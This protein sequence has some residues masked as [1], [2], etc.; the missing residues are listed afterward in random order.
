MGIFLVFG[1][2]SAIKSSKVADLVRALEGQKIQVEIGTSPALLKYKAPEYSHVVLVV[3]A[4]MPP[5]ADMWGTFFKNHKIFLAGALVKSTVPAQF[6]KFF[7]FNKD[8]KFDAPESVPSIV[9]WVKEAKLPEERPNLPPVPSIEPGVSITGLLNV[10]ETS[11]KEPSVASVVKGAEAPTSFAV[12]DD[13]LPASMSIE[14]DESPVAADGFSMS[15]I[16]A[17][18]DASAL[19]FG[20]PV[21]EV[22]N[23][24]DAGHIGESD[25]DP[26]DDLGDILSDD[27]P[28]ASRLE[29]SEPMVD[30]SLG[31]LSLQEASVNFG[32]RSHVAEAPLSLPS[33]SLVRDLGNEP[34]IDSLQEL[35]N[36]GDDTQAV[37]VV[38]RYALLK[39]RENREKQKSI[40]ILRSELAKM[41]ASHHAMQADK[42]KLMLKVDDI[43]ADRRALQETVDELR[44]KVATSDSDTSQKVRD[45]QARLENSQF[46]AKRFE[47]KLE[48]F[49]LRVRLDI[50]KIRAR[51]RELENRLELQ[52]RDAEAL[53]SNKDTR[54]LNQK[55]EIDRLQF[56]IEI[57]KERL[58]EETE[59][60]EDRSEKL[61]RAVQSLRMAQGMLSGID[62][63][64]IATSERQSSDGSDGGEAA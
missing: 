60:A 55:R 49:K 22:L 7:T 58:V 15:S 26:V 44:H 34:M 5:M 2:S 35:E 8:W 57:L 19:R 53:I 11:L 48:D 50:Q 39:E 29:V 63:E 28:A 32:G 12:E 43:E 46:Q 40:D 20:E 21:S 51:E 56:E 1:A 17:S 45:Y 25:E 59:K 3:D 36:S 10:N 42:R 64:V 30:Q 54:L 13:G 18:D 61:Q 38:K 31:E 47:K 52:K 14:K 41:K 4:A 27:A 33:G 37:Q 24:G 16:V 9:K 23:L 6:K 62:E